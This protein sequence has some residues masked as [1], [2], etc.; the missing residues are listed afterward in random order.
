MVLRFCMPA[1]VSVDHSLREWLGHLLAGIDGH[2]QRIVFRGGE[3]GT[4]QAMWED[5]A[6]RARIQEQLNDGAVDVVVLICCSK[7]FVETGFQYDQ[8]LFDIVA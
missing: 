8:A 3:N 5:P 7:E 1:T 6:V 2:E 4:P